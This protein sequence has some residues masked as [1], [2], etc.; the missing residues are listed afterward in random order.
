MSNTIKNNFIINASP[1]L[2]PSI[3]ISPFSFN[4]L[5]QSF[6]STEINQGHIEEIITKRFNNYSFE[7][8]GR[9]ALAKALSFYQLSELDIVTILTTSGNFYISSC[10]TKEIEKYCQWSRV[11]SN[12]TKVILVNHEFGYP[13]QNV[14]SLKKYGL[15]VIEDCAHSFFSDNGEIGTVGDFSIYSLPKAFPVQLGG[16]LVSNNPEYVLSESNV[17]VQKYIFSN[18]YTQYTE[19]QIR[20]RRLYNYYFL[21]KKLKKIQIY[22]YFPLEEGVIPGVFLF[23]WLDVINYPQL[24]IFMQANGVESSVFYGKNAFF[25]PCHHLLTEFELEY[26]ICLLEFFYHNYV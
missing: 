9:S 16:L 15:P 20:E 6:C 19:Q 12:K 13:Y 22:P 17:S 8:K 26:M 11:I 18:Y 4:S 25:I 3:R 14:G 23:S 7:L 5:R 24:K 2:T 10:V 21:K 1:E